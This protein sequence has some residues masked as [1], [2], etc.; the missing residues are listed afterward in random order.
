MKRTVYL[1]GALVLLVGVL[2]V[3]ANAGGDGPPVDVNGCTPDQTFYQ[4][5]CQAKSTP[6]TICHVAGLASDP[7]NYV[8]LHITLASAIGL[9]NGHLNENGTPLAGHEQDTLGECNPPP[10]PTEVSASVT[11]TEPSCETVAGYTASTTGVT[12]T[13]TSGT[14]APGNTITVTATADTGYVLV[15]QSVFTHTFGP[16]PTD[17]DEQDIPLSTG[18]TFT[19][20]TCTT[21]PS[22]HLVKTNIEGLGLRPF[23]NV[24]GPDFVDGHPVPGGTYTFAPIPIEGYVFVGGTEFTH[25]FALAP[26]DC[27][28]AHVVTG[29]AQVICLLPAG[30]YQLSGHVDGQAADSVSPATLSGNTK[31]VSNVVVTRGDTSVRTTVTTLGDC[32]TTTTVTVVPPAVTPAAVTTTTPPAAKPVVK[33]KPDRKPT[34]KPKAKP[35]PKPKAKPK[36]KKHKKPQKAPKTLGLGL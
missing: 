7:A 16:A 27:G 32:G 13:L 10:P 35:K 3:S 31:G 34:A 12:Y 17:C 14:V 6:I 18:V 30:V 21:P 28:G 9:P 25:T 11:F 2:A 15:G 26:T 22:F 24:E 20:A 19:E 1:L 29:D 33:P 4:G 5:S 36:A 23:Y 8:T